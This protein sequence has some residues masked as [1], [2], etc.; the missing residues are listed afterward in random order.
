MVVSLVYVPGEPEGSPMTWDNLHDEDV[1]FEFRGRTADQLQPGRF[2]QGTVDGFAEFGV[3]VTIGDSV[4]GLLH[5]SNIDGRLENLPWDVGDEVIVQVEGVRDNGNVDLSWSIRQRP[6]EFRGAGV[7]D[8]DG[9]ETDPA[10]SAPA[11][12][13]PDEAEAEEDEAEDEKQPS[14][15]LP[16]V[17]VES[18]DDH[19]DERL[20]ING[21]IVDVRQ[22][23]G[24]TIFSVAD[25]TG[26]V[27][28]AAFEAAGVRAY[29]DIETND[30]VT[31]VGR[32]ERHRGETQIEAETIEALA[33]SEQ[34]AVRTAIQSAQTERNQPDDDSLVVQQDV[35]DADALA[36][37]AT[38]IR[39]AVF[40]QRSVIIRHPTTVDGVVAGA[41]VEHAI[42][43]FADRVTSSDV[44]VGWFVT[45]RPIDSSW[46]NL[47][48]AM[49]DVS[50]GADRD[51][52]IV[53]V[54][55]GGSN[56]DAPALDF[57]EVYDTEYEIIDDLSSEGS[58]HISARATNVAGMIES[59]VRSALVHLPAIA[60]GREVPELY[61]SLADEH[62]Y[63]A[64][65]IHQRHDAIALVA[66]YQRYDDKRELIA[67]L[68]FD[69][70]EAGELAGHVS[71]QFRKRLR[72]AVETARENADQLTVSG[73]TILLLDADSL[74]HRYAFPPRPVL[75]DALHEDAGADVVLVLD[76]DAAFV[77]GSQPFDLEEIAQTIDT[78]VENASV[79]ATRDRITFL[80]GKRSEVRNAI[81]EP[82]IA[83][84]E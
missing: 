9:D 23:N 63:D 84:I 32:V 64:E 14:P 20:R 4:T 68:L 1:L 29:P 12:E 51:D 41:A 59:D 72:T 40:D 35:N 44:N 18:V 38:T 30:I 2:Y 36:E 71:E 76:E 79:E 80:A 15:A 28:C 10:P 60:A 73:G 65:T 5:R 3:F 25:E 77:A 21:K 31:V 17:D 74:T 57:L 50:D 48:D 78:D 19:V 7:H 6:A 16:T 81:V 27:E 70:K 13:E 69:G 22:T 56:R 45:R 83:E 55:T 11:E 75:A 54:G 66:Y 26:T 82:L 33:G 42:R 24:P 67:D 43:V 8:P 58:G 61:A 47:G 49:Y 46:Y 53:L 37:I 52:L 62:G 39:G 34:E